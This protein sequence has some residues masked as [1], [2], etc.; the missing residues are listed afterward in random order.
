M[1]WRDE[2]PERRSRRDRQ[3]AAL[4]FPWPDQVLTARDLPLLEEG[5]DAASEQPYRQTSCHYPI[6]PDP[7]AE[8]FFITLQRE[9]A[10]GFFS[11]LDEYD[12]R[13][14]MPEVRMEQSGPGKVVLYFNI[15]LN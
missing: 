6:H 3:T 5:C 13:R 10:E 14:V 9:V 2:G 4:S 1:R 8:M 12:P 15:S 7:G 11:V